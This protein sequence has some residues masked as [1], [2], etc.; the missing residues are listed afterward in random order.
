MP[1]FYIAYKKGDLELFSEFIKDKKDKFVND[2]YDAIYVGKGDE[3]FLDNPEKKAELIEFFNKQNI[4]LICE[5][6]GMEFGNK[7]MKASE[8]NKIKPFDTYLISQVKFSN[9]NENMLK[10][11]NYLIDLSLDE[12]LKVGIHRTG[13]NCSGKTILKDGLILTGHASSGVFKKSYDVSDIENNISFYDENPGLLISQI[14]LGGS[15]KNYTQRDADIMLVAI[16][17]VILNNK[18]NNIIL[19]KKPQ[20][21]LNPEYIKGYVTVDAKNNEMKSITDNPSF[22]KGYLDKDEI[23]TIQ[24]AKQIENEEIK[25]SIKNKTE[26]KQSTANQTEAW[27]TTLENYYNN[28]PKGL[29]KKVTDYLKRIVKSRDKH[30]IDKIDNK[31]ENERD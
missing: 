7:I 6:F 13:G 15:Y 10:I 16:P 11:M 3:K 25:D 17:K 27:M 4:N 28:T 30:N 18:E 19:E 9:S 5:K 20:N 31:D 24:M 2:S 21:V 8:E 26:Q 23:E 1:A 12:N 14:A 29:I 22:L